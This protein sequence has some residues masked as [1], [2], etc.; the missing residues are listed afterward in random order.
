MSDFINYNF[1]FLFSFIATSFFTWLLIFNLPSFGMVDIPDPRRVHNKITPRGGGIAI[2]IV[3][4]IGLITYEYF[5]TEMLINSIKIVPLLLIISTISFL[6]DLVSIPVFI[7]LIIHIICSTI[8][9]I[10]FLSPA[11]LFHHEL[12]LYI[13][14]VLS[15]IYLITFLNIYNF[16]DGI[17]GISGAESIHLSITILILCYLKYDTII[18]INFII[19]LNIIILGCSIGF[20]IFNWHP[21][22]IFIGDV[23]SISLGFLLGLCLILISASSI[24]LF[25]ASSI[26]SLYYM[27]DGGLTILIRLLNKEKIWQPHLK[28]FF[29]KAVKNG[30]SHR[31]VVCRIIICNILL[32]VLS[33]TSLYFPLV[34]TIFAV[35]VVMVTIINFA[36]ET[37]QP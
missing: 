29:Q 23:G 5:V 12:P 34:S 28:H 18:N 11:L 1:L 25:I 24:H 13:D 9:I 3:V 30:K 16:L 35:L 26:A 4:I 10:L 19:V 36:H 7:R 21:A 8:S 31:E 6:D 33:I 32:M 22:K 37:T 14:F 17:D 20:L 15:I 2:V 27:T